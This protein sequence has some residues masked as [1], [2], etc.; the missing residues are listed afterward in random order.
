MRRLASLGI[1]I[2]TDN[3]PLTKLCLLADHPLATCR[4]PKDG[5]AEVVLI[6]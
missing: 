3:F 4:R 1:F 2:S 6:V 5:D